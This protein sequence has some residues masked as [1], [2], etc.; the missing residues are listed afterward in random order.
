MLPSL[1]LYSG[2][3]AVQ[4]IET[5]IGC[6]PIGFRGR[7]IHGPGIGLCVLALVKQHLFLTLCL[8]PSSLLSSV[9]PLSV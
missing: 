1:R 4:K 2:I 3:K 8:D 6:N 5:S 9:S 7:I